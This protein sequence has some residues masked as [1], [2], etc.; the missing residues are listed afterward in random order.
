MP[1]PNEK[2][3]QSLQVGLKKSKMK[4]VHLPV[5]PLRWT[6]WGSG[7]SSARSKD[8]ILTAL[9]P[10]AIGKAHGTLC[11]TEDSSRLGLSF[12]WSMIQL[13]I[14]ILGLKSGRGWA[15]EGFLCC[16]CML[17]S[18]ST[19]PSPGTEQPDYWKAAEQ[20]IMAE[21]ERVYLETK[22]Q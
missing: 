13:Q 2:C 21:A 8:F 4:G 9:L 16:T 15:E 11:S 18:F 3:G 20:N 22:L 19:S 5:S 1:V 14:R 7:E 10:S 12:M 6:G 17:G